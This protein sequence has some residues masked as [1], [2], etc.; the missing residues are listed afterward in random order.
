MSASLRAGRDAAKRLRLKVARERTAGAL[1]HASRRS[2]SAV[3]KAGG[4][5]RRAVVEVQPPGNSGQDRGD[6]RA[7]EPEFFPLVSA[8]HEFK[9]PL[10]A[11]LGYTDL[12]RN[13]QLGPVTENQQQVLGEIQDSAERLQRL[14]QD[15]LLLCELRTGRSGDPGRAARSK[16]NPHVR[17]IFNYWAPLAMQKSITY[18]FIPA[19]GEPWVSV[20]ALKLQHIV[21]NLIENAIKF[22]PPGGLVTVSLYPCFWDRRR[23]HTDF[24]FN[25]QRRRDRKIENA[26]RI[27]VCDTGPGIHPDHHE[28]IFRDFVQLPITSSRGTGLGLAIAR[29]L[30]E[31]HG[32]AIWVESEPGRGSKFSLLLIES[33]YR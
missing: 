13:G 1:P 28:A 25:L 15:L 2:R 29:R 5:G 30:T 10:V 4:D 9:T 33:R 12:M 6:Q 32:G 3:E 26:L 14:I 27:D 31:T 7:M 19:S 21:S 20:D 22:T 8:A 24:L 11:M 16:A 23:P 17:E 18:Q